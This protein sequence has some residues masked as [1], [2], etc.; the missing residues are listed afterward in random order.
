MVSNNFS[1]H[2]YDGFTTDDL[3]LLLPAAQK[4]VEVT[5]DPIE[6]ELW[7]VRVSKMEDELIRRQEQQ[8]EVEI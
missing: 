6:R 5:E 7:K 1:S 8:D 2:W 4:C 3:V